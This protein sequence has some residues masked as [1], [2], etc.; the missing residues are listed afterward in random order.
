MWTNH[1]AVKLLFHQPYHDINIVSAKTCTATRHVHFKCNC[2]S[3]QQT[4][5]I[6]NNKYGPTVQHYISS[7]T[8]TT[9]IRKTSHIFHQ[10]IMQPCDPY[11][12]PFD[13]MRSFTKFMSWIPVHQS[14][15]NLRPFDLKIITHTARAMDNMCTK[16]ETSSVIIL[17]LKWSIMCRVGCQNL[18]TYSPSSYDLWRDISCP[19]PL[20]FYLKSALSVTRDMGHLPI[21]LGFLKLLVPELWAQNR[22]R[23]RGKLHNATSNTE[24]RIMT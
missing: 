6:V 17:S 5:I 20:M 7:T 19:C 10:I 11:L 16:F 9:F 2:T 22:Q 21:N 13:S 4:E 24:G 18:Y 12:W 3:R 15:H 1:A 8:Y 23:D 14:R